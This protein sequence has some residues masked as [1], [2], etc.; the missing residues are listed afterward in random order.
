MAGALSAAGIAKFKRA[1][2]RVAG[3][4]DDLVRQDIALPARERRTCGAVLAIRPWEPAA[5]SRLRRTD[6]R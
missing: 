3:E 5:F 4:F 6:C 2:D 1:L